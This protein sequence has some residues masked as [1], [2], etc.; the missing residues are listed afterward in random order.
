MC[1]RVKKVC[2][3]G[4]R[5][6]TDGSSNITTKHDNV[7]TFSTFSK[8]RSRGIIEHTPLVEN[9]VDCRKEELRHNV[10]APL[11]G[12]FRLGVGRG[13]HGGCLL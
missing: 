1:T 5:D 4:R 8:R 13:R 12:D 9:G 11:K 10:D 6:G 2:Q 3:L 7:T